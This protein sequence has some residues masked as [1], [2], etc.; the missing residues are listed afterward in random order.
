MLNK[1][2]IITIIIII[3]IKNVNDE[4]IYDLLYLFKVHLIEVNFNSGSLIT[5]DARWRFIPIKIDLSQ[6][7][8]ISYNSIEYFMEGAN[9]R[10]SRKII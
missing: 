4:E 6:R 2:F 9:I 5:I 3:I 7:N 8:E 10:Y 1:L